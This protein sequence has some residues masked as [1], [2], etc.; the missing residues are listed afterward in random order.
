MTS[1]ASPTRPLDLLVFIFF[2]AVNDSES[3]SYSDMSDYNT[4][5]TTMMATYHNIMIVVMDLT[6]GLHC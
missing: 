5:I 6:A 1:R 4:T 2:H 3:Q